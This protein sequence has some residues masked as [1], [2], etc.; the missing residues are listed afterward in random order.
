MTFSCCK[1]HNALL[2]TVALFLVFISSSV[3]AQTSTPTLSYQHF[4]TAQ[5]LMHNT[6]YGMFQDSD[7]YL[8]FATVNGVDRFDGT[9]FVHFRHDPADSL[10]LNPASNYKCF[11]E[12]PDGTLWIGSL[13]GLSALDRRTGRC[14][15]YSNIGSERNTLLDSRVTALLCDSQGR[16][17]IGTTKGLQVLDP[18]TKTMTS[19]LESFR[20]NQSPAL[21]DNDFYIQNIYEL[22]D[23]NVVIT[24]AYKS[25]FVCP[26]GR[27]MTIRHFPI[28]CSEAYALLSPES[29]PKGSVFVQAFNPF[30]HEKFQIWSVNLTTGLHSSS[31]P[32]LWEGIQRFT[33]SNGNKDITKHPM[34]L[35]H[36]SAFDEQKRAF[37]YFWDEHRKEKTGLYLYDDQT[38]Q[39]EMVLAGSAGTFFVDKKGAFW[40]SVVN[41]STNAQSEPERI[42]NSMAGVWRIGKA[43]L[44][45]YTQ[46]NGLVSTV[47]N[48]FCEES[49]TKLLFAATDKGLHVFHR[50][51]GTWEN[52]RNPALGRTKHENVMS[53][54]DHPTKPRHLL[55][56]MERGIF[57]YDLVRKQFREIASI[58][59]AIK[60]NSNVYK[61]L[62]SKRTG[63]LWLS[64]SVN[65]LDCFTVESGSG[66]WKHIRHIYNNDSR[67]GIAISCIRSLCLDEDSPSRPP[68]VWIGGTEGI[69]RWDF[70]RGA[71]TQSILGLATVQHVT[72][73]RI[74]AQDSVIALG[75][76][77]NY[78]SAATESFIPFSTE[79]K[80][81]SILH[82]TFQIDQSGG[83]WWMNFGGDFYHA[84]T[85]HSPIQTIST[86]QAMGYQAPKSITTSDGAFWFSRKSGIL[87]VH[88]ATTE[89]VPKRKQPTIASIF[90]NDTRRAISLPHNDTLLVHYGDSFGVELSALALENL[91][92]HDFTGNQYSCFLEGFDSDWLP[93]STSRN[94]RYTNLEPGTYFL[95]YAC[96]SGISGTF[97]AQKPLVVIITPPY[98]KRW[99]FRL[100]VVLLVVGV[101]AFG[102]YLFIR[103]ERLKSR[104]THLRLH[105]L[106]LKMNPHFLFNTINTLK[107][108]VETSPATAAEYIDTFA[109]MMRSMLLESDK[110]VISLAQEMTILE[111]YLTMEQLR[112]SFRFNFKVHFE[113]NPSLAIASERLYIPIMLIQ[114]IVENALKHGIRS[115]TDGGIVTIRFSIRP[116]GKPRDDGS[117]TS[118]YVGEC[119]IEDNGIGRAAAK[120]RSLNRKKQENLSLS[121]LVINE[122]IQIF[123]RIYK[124]PYTPPSIEDLHHPDGSAVGTR[125][126]IQFPVWHEET[127]KLLFHLSEQQEIE[128]QSV[129]NQK[130]FVINPLLN[131]Q[132]SGKIFNTNN[133]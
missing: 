15:R 132:K 110:E 112:L 84:P 26:P 77:I 54:I 20:T 38:K 30:K 35:F 13:S 8:W 104:I 103:D 63:E 40:T 111:Q 115:L 64:T 50:E 45:T 25:L 9:N 22:P 101:I 36:V 71:I 133:N 52:L 105:T 108:E 131:W 87:T 68:G 109:D 113:V 23:G 42:G 60:T 124:I 89:A 34:Y 69:Q 16:L 92:V 85:N 126:R 114:P 28:K 72:D 3:V 17:W 7:G 62:Y 19:V 116:T 82:G 14:K 47:V 86:T 39:C 120:K 117:I 99:E 11:A 1:R 88:P 12:T 57:E 130:G 21:A 128:V 80:V 95:H 74:S 97:A 33:L 106:R 31:L 27:G 43:P 44:T 46:Q 59:R 83:V 102:L 58:N 56:G 98:W 78:Y 32:P 73:I 121:T 96:S 29:A 61:L 100:F 53:I 119:V 41:P 90:Q 107:N 129:V 125:V 49:D 81:V 2:T 94:F 5:G 4:T 127:A 79:Q 18:K 10:S 76:N 123:E 6:V 51:L 91:G 118:K 122:R 55:L 48:G 37:C 24:S 70:S 75:G 65:G 67:R 66:S 93:M